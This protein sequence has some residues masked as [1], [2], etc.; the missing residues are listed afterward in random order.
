MN[1]YF[2]KT[3]ALIARNN[4]GSSHTFGFVFAG[5]CF[6]GA[7]ALASFCYREAYHTGCTFATRTG[8][9]G[10][11]ESWTKMTKLPTVYKRSR[12]ALTRSVPLTS[13]PLTRIVMALLCHA[14][15]R[16]VTIDYVVCYVENNFTAHIILY[17]LVGSNAGEGGKTMRDKLYRKLKRLPKVGSHEAV[18]GQAWSRYL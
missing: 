13:R 17:I 15:Y 5:V 18:A 9:S 8:M 16:I 3:R 1:K 10:V 11:L 12:M 7:G 6:C 4:E 14:R 2:N